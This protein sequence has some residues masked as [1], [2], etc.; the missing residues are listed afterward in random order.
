MSPADYR[1][2]RERLGLTQ[3]ELADRLGVSRGTVN[4][5]EAG[6]PKTPIT[7]EAALAL[8]ALSSAPPKKPRRP[9]SASAMPT[10]NASGEPC[11]PPA[12]QSPKY[13]E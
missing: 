7:S 13:H 4:R 3:A 6:D 5:R 11:P 9:R 8:D 12:N 2:T 10:S 1:A